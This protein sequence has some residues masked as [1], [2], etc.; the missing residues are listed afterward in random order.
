LF[1][2]TGNVLQESANLFWDNTNSRLGIGNA[3]PVSKLHIGTA[4]GT[5]ATGLTFGSGVSG[6]YL[7]DNTTMNI[8]I[9]SADRFWFRSTDFYPDINIGIDLGLTSR[10][11]K[12]LNTQQI[13]DNGSNVLIGTTTDAGYKLDVN[14]ST[15]IVGT[16]LGSA[17]TSASTY[18]VA[19]G[20][21]A[22][23]T[24]AHGIAIGYNALASV[25]PSY[26]FGYNATA[27]AQYATAFSRGTASAINSVAWGNLTVANG[28]GSIAGGDG[29]YSY[30]N[31]QL[32][33]GGY[34]TYRGDSQ[35]S[36]YTGNLNTG[37]VSSGGTYSFTGIRPSNYQFSVDVSQ[38]WYVECVVVFAVKGKTAAITEFALRDTYSIKYKLALKS[39]NSFG[40]TI[41]GTPIADS[42]FSDASMS[43]TSVTFTIVSNNLVVNVTP[44]VWLSG[45]QMQFRGTASF[46]I[47]E[48][49]VYSQPF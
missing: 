22:Q 49:G 21:N 43:T 13:T 5:L 4:V 42:T 10:R 38:I 16:L 2:G 34:M 40:T 20:Y 26:A 7:L 33:I 15:R 37:I 23:G 39:T 14:G 3:A 28:V 45:G 32:T 46:Q 9:N 8:K 41:I 12:T 27:S 44:P 19:L 6:I 18:G 25:N 47:T 31:N 29:T 30:L 1:Q 11:W 24:A 35:Y 17:A 48:L 36:L